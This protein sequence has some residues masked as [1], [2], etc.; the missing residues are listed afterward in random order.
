MY[1]HQLSTRYGVSKCAET[2]A[3]VA[4]TG[5]HRTSAVTIMS[6]FKA[7]RICRTVHDPDLVGD[8]T[9]CLG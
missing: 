4:V 9:A 7:I 2:E 8:S 6:G 5:W 3:V 1:C